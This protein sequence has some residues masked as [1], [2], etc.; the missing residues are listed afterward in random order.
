MK[1]YL[2]LGSLVL[3][4]LAAGW[5]LGHRKL[6]ANAPPPAES[7]QDA[8]QSQDEAEA[9]P[10]SGTAVNSAATGAG[11]RV[12]SLVQRT[13]QY[14]LAERADE[15]SFRR[16]P[17]IPLT[18]LPPA[19][20]VKSYPGPLEARTPE[21][22]VWLDRHG[23][24]T[25]AEVDALD[26]TSANALAERAA[27]GDLAAMA[28]LGKKQIQNQETLGTG[29]DNLNEAA[30]QGS[31]WAILV[32]ADHQ[33]QVGNYKDAFALYN[34]AALRGDWV[35]SEIHMVSMPAQLPQ[36]AFAGVPRRT[37][38][39]FVAMQALRQQRGLPPLVN[40]PRPNIFNRP[41]GREPI[42]VYRRRGG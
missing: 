3:A 25:Q 4:G 32:L 11:V 24:P 39:H 9:T 33:R 7:I 2:L 10:A 18:D 8:A 40:T 19:D 20:E 28:L 30:L 41:D 26:T 31:I 29:Y 35:S 12:P 13:A 5:L 42:G 22:A 6:T 38:S 23:Y 16:S 37:A 15:P 34:L 27:Q 14:F 21:E 1:R 36:L 17:E